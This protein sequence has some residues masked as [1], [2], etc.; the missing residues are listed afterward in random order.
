MFTEA[1][2]KKQIMLEHFNVAVYQNVIDYHITIDNAL[3]PKPFFNKVLERKHQYHKSQ[4][5]AAR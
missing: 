3:N 2:K 4:K 5:R 1:R